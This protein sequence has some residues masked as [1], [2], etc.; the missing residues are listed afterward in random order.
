MGAAE[1]RRVGGYRLTE[2]QGLWFLTDDAGRAVSTII[3]MGEGVWRA[4][5]PEGGA[6]TVQ[7]PPDVEDPALFIAEEITKTGTAPPGPPVPA[8]PS[9]P[10]GGGRCAPA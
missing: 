5:T 2:Y 4:R 1:P 6:R 7:V 9:P 10:P 8:A 3:D